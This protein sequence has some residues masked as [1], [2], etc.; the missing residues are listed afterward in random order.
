MLLETENVVL[1]KTERLK[2]AIEWYQLG[3]DFADAMHLA[4]CNGATIHTFDRYFCKA[5]RKAGLT[6]EINIVKT[7]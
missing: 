5:A 7:K 2:K 1:K 4:A 6:P 3:S